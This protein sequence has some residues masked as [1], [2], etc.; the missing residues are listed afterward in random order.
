MTMACTTKV[1]QLWQQQLCKIIMIHVQKSQSRLT[2]PMPCIDTSFPTL[3]KAYFA[4][5]V[6]RAIRWTVT[7]GRTG[8]TRDW[9]LMDLWTLCQSVSTSWRGSGSQTLTSWM[10]DDHYCTPW[11]HP[12]NSYVFTKMAPFCTQWGNTPNIM[13]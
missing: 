12:T 9:R 11:L 5:Y 1:C 10:A 4:I 7:S 6:I 2:W 13:V 3:Q 8:L